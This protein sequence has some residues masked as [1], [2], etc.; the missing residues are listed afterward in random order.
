[1]RAHVAEGHRGNRVALLVAG[2]APDAGQLPCLSNGRGRS[3][4]GRTVESDR[5]WWPHTGHRNRRAVSPTSSSGRAFRSANG[6]QAS[7]PQDSQTAD[8]PSW[9]ELMRLP[10]VANPP[11]SASAILI[12]L[13]YPELSRMSL[14]RAAPTPNPA[15]R[16]YS[17]GTSTWIARVL[18]REQRRP[19]CALN[20]VG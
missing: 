17:P 1:V 12:R 4:Q 6:T 8:R 16:S 2:A 9:P 13:R 20:N 3:F 5:T 18:A 14:R 19:A 7:R 15:P 11:R 10:T